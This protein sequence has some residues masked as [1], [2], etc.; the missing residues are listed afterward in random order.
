MPKHATDSVWRKIG[1]LF[2]KFQIFKKH[3]QK[4]QKALKWS[5][6]QSKLVSHSLD[7][8]NFQN[9]LINIA[10]YI[11]MLRMVYLDTSCN[12]YGNKML[13]SVSSRFLTF[14]Q[15]FSC[16]TPQCYT[17][18]A[19]LCILNLSLEFSHEFGNTLYLPLNRLNKILNSECFFPHSHNLTK[20]LRFLFLLTDGF[21]IILSTLRHYRH[22]I[23]FF[24]WWFKLVIANFS[25]FINSVLVSL[26]KQI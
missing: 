26:K 6:H 10:R 21:I 22:L 5:S 14:R 7:I 23:F 2:H 24:T 8:W 16:P 1:V 18:I 4:K 9:H 11:S 25:Q 20:R 15:N 13:I 12:F 3:F 19:S 17:K